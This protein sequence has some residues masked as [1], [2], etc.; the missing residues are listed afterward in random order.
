M[1]LIV[2]VVSREAMARNQKDSAMSEIQNRLNDAAKLGDLSALHRLFAKGSDP[3]FDLSQ[4]L[5][6][7]A[8]AG[9]LDASSGSSL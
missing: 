7:A 2:V 3:N 9:K 1:I 5:A 8:G 4:T 6:V